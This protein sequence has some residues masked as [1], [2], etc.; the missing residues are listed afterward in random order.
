MK[1]CKKCLIPKDEI[2]FS[3]RKGT[4]DGLNPYCRACMKETNAK[5]YKNNKES[6]NKKAKEWY[7]KNKIEHNRKSIQYRKEN[8]CK[9]KQY[10]QKWRENNKEYFRKWRKD[11]YDKD[12]SF[13][14]RVILGNRLKEVLTKNK[15]YKTNSLI[16]LLGCTLHELKVYIE[17]QFLPE[18]NW[19]NQGKVWELDHTEACANFD[20]SNIKEQKQCFNYK[21]LKPLFKTTEI[22]ENHG[23]LNEIGNRN[24]S[25]N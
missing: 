2:E 5:S 17:Q 13:R 3:K 20:L 19:D 24:K 21:N 6:H 18:M 11:K 12:P 15:T 22:A 7:D 14:L 16:E 23:Y 8:P 1:N 25:S 10:Q 4:E 9:N